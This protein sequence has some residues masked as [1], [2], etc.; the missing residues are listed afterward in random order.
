VKDK[1]KT[2]EKLIEE[3]K[4]SRRQNSEL[5][6]KEIEFQKA[7]E[8]EK[9]Y[10][11]DLKSLSK[12]SVG[13]VDLSYE[14]DIYQFIAKQLKE[15]IDNCIVV[16]NSFNEESST[17]CVRSVLGITKHMNRILKILGRHPVG[18]S[19]P[20]NGEAREG[21]TSG[22]LEKVPGGIYELSIGSISKP[23]CRA[24][25]KL[26][27]LGDTYAMGFSWRGKLF[28]SAVV[29]LPK[30]V[31]IGNQDIIETFIRQASVA[32]QRRQAEEAL[33]K[34]NDELEIRVRKRTAE[35]AKANQE[36]KAEITD[37]KQAEKRL[38]QSEERYRST[39][40]NMMEGCQIIGYDWRYLYVNDTVARHGQRS[41]EEL[42]GKTMMEIYPGIEKTEMFSTLRK[43]M[44][45]RISAY[46]ENEFI[47]PDGEKGWFELCIQPSPEGIFI[48]SI[49]I[50]ERKRAE[51]KI[52]NSL[53]E[54]EVLLKEIHHRVK[55]NMQVISSLL[56]IQ[57]TWIEEEKALEVL[58][59]TR[60]RV[61]SMALI[62]D[63]LYKSEDLSRVD[64]GQYIEQI[65]T[66]LLGFY[67]NKLEK[68]KIKRDVKNV[69]I[70]IHKAVP[71]GLIINELIS[72]SLKHAFPDEMEGE[73]R[74]KFH[75]KDGMY[76]LI[77]CDDGVGF[78]KDL[79]FLKTQSMGMQLVTS[80]V[81]Q[82]DGEIKLDR[83]P[84]TS[85]KITFQE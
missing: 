71:L 54:K 28:G 60:K 50:T 30:G 26:L 74:I 78:S 62:H 58:K 80:L 40:D 24:I 37:R 73:L 23:A 20:I 49:D 64:F 16:M 13:L 5:R 46:M 44:K 35:L 59:D 48:L 51:E 55:N 41:K 21:L 27:G 61:Y 6:R 7:G 4:K 9:R 75:K 14:E 8:K 68:V 19:T 36:L 3:L 39:L 32:L 85:F 69:F 33:Q 70:A 15:L 65:S 22:K 81:D 1:N 82:I 11:R 52:K 83:K 34:V 17:F 76:E 67:R 12:M 18:M 2:K 45:E 31:E 43:C 77:I 38:K 79:D 25:E 63:R 53:K 84:H 42:L 47:F 29:F 56:N 10:I 57:S 72:N 66:H